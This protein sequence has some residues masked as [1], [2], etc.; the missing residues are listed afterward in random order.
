MKSQG[1]PKRRIMSN[2]ITQ[3][4]KGWG[5]RCPDPAW[6][7][8][9]RFTNPP[10]S[11]G[12]DLRCGAPSIGTLDRTYFAMAPWAFFVQKKGG[13]KEGWSVEK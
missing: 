5:K 12:H 9:Q 1:P 3:Y 7:S 11:Q 2:Y 6:F 10:T 13:T 8:S 4:L